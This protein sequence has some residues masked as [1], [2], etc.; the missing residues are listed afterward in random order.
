MGLVQLKASLHIKHDGTITMLRS[1]PKGYN[2]EKLECSGLS[3]SEA[4]QTTEPGKPL[5]NIKRCPKASRI[6]LKMSADLSENSQ[7][8][9]RKAD[10]VVWRQVLTLDADFVQGDPGLNRN[11]FDFACAIYFNP[12]TQPGK[13]APAS[14]IPLARPVTLTSTRRSA[15]VWRLTWVLIAFDDTTYEPHRRCTGRP[16]QPMNRIPLPG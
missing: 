3:P 5:L 13:T 8:R 4:R 7:R 6:T 14:V 10:A 1:K 9:Q 16:P 15:D 11:V 12:Q 2:L